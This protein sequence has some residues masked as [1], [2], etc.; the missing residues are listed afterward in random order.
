MRDAAPCERSIEDAWPRNG[1]NDAMRCERAGSRAAV[2]VLR[3]RHATAK[4]D[5]RRRA[6]MSLSLAAASRFDR[7][8]VRPCIF[9]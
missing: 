1:R 7:R 6:T 2:M 5:P 9:R 8:S 4:P 3:G